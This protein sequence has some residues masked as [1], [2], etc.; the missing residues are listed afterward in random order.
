M[1]LVYNTAILYIDL[2]LGDPQN[3]VHVYTYYIHI[4]ATLSSYSTI[5]L[6]ILWY[7]HAIIIN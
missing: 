1:G 3:Y 7:T 2:G 5:N 4:N 6:Q